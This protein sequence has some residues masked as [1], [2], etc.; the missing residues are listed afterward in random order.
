METLST[1]K[2]RNYAMRFSPYVSSEMTDAANHLNAL[3][4]HGGLDY[5]PCGGT[6]MDHLVLKSPDVERPANS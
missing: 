3:V 6:S 4:R 5:D 2:L 1:V